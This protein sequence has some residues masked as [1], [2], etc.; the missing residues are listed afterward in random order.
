[1]HHCSHNL[2]NYY[3][4]TVCLDDRS[5]DSYTCVLQLYLDCDQTADSQVIGL[6][7]VSRILS[8]GALPRIVGGWT[9]SDRHL[10]VVE[11]SAESLRASS[12][13]VKQHRVLCLAGDSKKSSPTATNFNTS[14][15]VLFIFAIQVI[16]WEKLDSESPDIHCTRS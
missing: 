10:F 3:M 6:S 12:S 8:A 15:G 1:M 16:I 7:I 11:A 4:E 5:H 2:N 9:H 14:K 13:R